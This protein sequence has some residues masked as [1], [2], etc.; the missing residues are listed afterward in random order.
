MATK[1][2]AQGLTGLCKLGQFEEAM[3]RY[4]A[5]EIVSIEAF[6]D[7]AETRGFAATLEKGK[8]FM[9]N[10]EVHGAET[11]GPYIN[12]DQFVVHFKIDVTEKATGKR[13]VLDEVGVYTVQNDKIV[14]ERFF[15]MTA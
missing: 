3:T 15:P 6:G 1:D 4:Y 5:P 9:D 10:H 12:G 11:E 8:W 14:H 13:S 7:P 2:V